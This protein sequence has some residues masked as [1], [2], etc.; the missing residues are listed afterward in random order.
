M[1]R[2]LDFTALRIDS[3]RR[4]EVDADTD[5]LRRLM[6][7]AATPLALWPWL[8]MAALLLLALEWWLGGHAGA[9]RSPAIR[10]SA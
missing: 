1:V 5:A 9:G 2:E 8:A 4:V 6:W 10:S 7:S 3:A